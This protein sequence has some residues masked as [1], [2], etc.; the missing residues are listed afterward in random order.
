MLVAQEDCIS[1]ELSTLSLQNTLLV[2]TL[3][4]PSS[5]A[6][7]GVVFSIVGPSDASVKQWCMLEAQISIG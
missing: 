5:S 2:L 7:I 6:Y 4:R 3:M 1:L